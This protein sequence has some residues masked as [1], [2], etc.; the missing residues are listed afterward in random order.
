MTDKTPNI[1]LGDVVPNFTADSTTG[2]LVKQFFSYMVL[3]VC[4][5]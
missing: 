2:K 4:V 3:R 1:K 5:F